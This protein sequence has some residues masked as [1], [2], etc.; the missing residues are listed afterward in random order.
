MNEQQPLDDRFPG[1]VVTPGGDGID[2]AE[3]GVPEFIAKDNIGWRKIADVRWGW[4]TFTQAVKGV[5]DR[6]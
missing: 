6:L 5:M 3:Q 2:D 4:Q 1:F